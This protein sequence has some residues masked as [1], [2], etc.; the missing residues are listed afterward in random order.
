MSTTAVQIYKR[1]RST[2]NPEKMATHLVGILVYIQA[3]S[4]HGT[5]FSARPLAST[6]ST[7]LTAIRPRQDPQSE[8]GHATGQVKNST[9]PIP[10]GGMKTSNQSRVDSSFR[11]IKPRGGALTRVTTRQESWGLIRQ[12]S[13]PAAGAYMRRP[14][15]IKSA[16]GPFVTTRRRPSRISSRVRSGA[17]SLPARGDTRP[18]AFWIAHTTVSRK[19]AWSGHR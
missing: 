16:G 13:R 8:M 17:M 9:P 7:T 12:A 15:T 3:H 5:S 19:E 18:T 14:W 4:A 10:R 11:M 6:P 1:R 2:P